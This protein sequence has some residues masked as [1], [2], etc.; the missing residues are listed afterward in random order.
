MLLEYDP[1]EKVAY[2][3]CAVMISKAIQEFEGLTSKG[4]AAYWMQAASQISAGLRERRSPDN[5]YG[6]PRH[7][8]FGVS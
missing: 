6:S 5:F 8:Q 4:E 3:R 2:E 7:S 1:V